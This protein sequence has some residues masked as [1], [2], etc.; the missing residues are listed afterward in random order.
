MADNIADRLREGVKRV[1]E[2][3]PLIQLGLT[4]GRVAD[5][6]IDLY[7]TGKEYLKRSPARD[8]ALPKDKR[9]PTKKV[10][11]VQRSLMRGG[12]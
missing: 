12:R 6:A 2:S 1:G 8:I 5:K 3:E 10:A 11:P 7:Q 9:R 4:M